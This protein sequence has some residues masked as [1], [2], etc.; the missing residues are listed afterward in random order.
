[1]NYLLPGLSIQECQGDTIVVNLVN[2]MRT[3]RVT[4]I[5]WHGLTQ[6]GTPFM[7]G[8]GMVT[9]YPIMPFQSFQY[10]F[11]AKDVGTY[12]WHSHSGVQRAVQLRI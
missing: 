10:K 2:R 8:V 9:Q 11:E 3:A 6:R 4:S 7:D 1:V 12:W 5:H